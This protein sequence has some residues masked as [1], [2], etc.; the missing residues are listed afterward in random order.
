MN[1]LDKRLREGLGAIHPLLKTNSNI[2][3]IF[4][5]SV[6]RNRTKFLNTHTVDHL[7]VDLH[8]IT[9]TSET[10]LWLVRFKSSSIMLNNHLDHIG[11]AINAVHLHERTSGTA[12]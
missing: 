5:H 1:S 7:I 12:S 8:R 10:Y 6:D 9:T 4:S 3:L 2:P 11:K